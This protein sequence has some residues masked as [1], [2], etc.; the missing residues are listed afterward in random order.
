[1][2][3]NGVFFI[4]TQISLSCFLQFDV[5]CFVH[6]V[7]TPFSMRP[8][9]QPVDTNDLVMNAALRRLVGGITGVGA[10]KKNDMDLNSWLQEKLGLTK[11]GVWRKLKPETGAWEE[12]DLFIVA[13]GLGLTLD[14]LLFA[15]ACRGTRVVTANVD[16]AGTRTL[17]KVV[18]GDLLGSSPANGIAAHQDGDLWSVV[19]LLH[20]NVQP[21]TDLYEVAGINMAEVVMR[22]TVVAL[23]DDE[24]PVTE[25]ASA[26]L[27][28]EGLDSQCFDDTPS[29]LRACEATK[30]DAIVVDWQLGNQTA[31]NLIKRF[32][33]S[34]GNAT[35]PVTLV[36]GQV[37]S[38]DDSVVD[39]LK[40]VSREFGCRVMTKP[41]RWRLV[42]SDLL[43]QIE[44]TQRREVTV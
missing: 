13:K 28:L 24:Q 36:T 32:R 8:A 2:K 1:M 22:R 31:A 15:I 6:N 18:I 19:S 26:L 29:F 25:N 27:K 14:E 10:D 3:I 35:T 16:V 17:R 40:H 12:R 37:S 30:F 21:G 42:A 39:E 23:I 44:E 4:K 41:V 5:S 11:S 20:G 43:Q 9:R 33:E 38:D 34:N 7:H